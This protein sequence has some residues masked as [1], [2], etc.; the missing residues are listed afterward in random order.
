MPRIKVKS[1]EVFVLVFQDY[2]FHV[3]NSNEQRLAVFRKDEFSMFLDDGKVIAFHKHHKRCDVM[4]EG[5]DKI[6]KYMYDT[7]P[8][9]EYAMFEKWIIS[10]T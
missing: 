10:K 3:I 4:M 9:D 5:K 1:K 7:L 8:F 6:I 2:M